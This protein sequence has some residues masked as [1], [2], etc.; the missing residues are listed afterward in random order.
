[1]ALGVVKRTVADGT[2]LDAAGTPAAIDGPD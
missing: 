2:V 1:V